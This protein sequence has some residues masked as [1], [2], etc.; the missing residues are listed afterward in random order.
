MDVASLE[1]HT[2]DPARA[3]ALCAALG[4]S[5]EI[6]ACRAGGGVWLPYARV[7]CVDDAVA[8]ASE[9][10]ARVLAPAGDNDAGRRALVTVGGAPV[11]LWSSSHRSVR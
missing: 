1:L 2:G 11:V 8:V 10:G 5:A 9:H 7:G 3:R 6:V 4:W